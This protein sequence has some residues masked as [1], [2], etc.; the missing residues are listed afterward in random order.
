MCTVTVNHVKK[1]I[2]I[3]QSHNEELV[4][5]DILPAPG[6]RSTIQGKSGSGVAIN[7]GGPGNDKG[8]R[9]DET[10]KEQGKKEQRKQENRRRAKSG[11]RKKVCWTMGTAILLHLSIYI[12]FWFMMSPVGGVE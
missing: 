8:N 10:G 9:R 6:N 12:F 1:I 4:P 3:F 5:K 11:R 2:Q 7:R